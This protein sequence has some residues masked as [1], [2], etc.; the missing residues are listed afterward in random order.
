MYACWRLVLDSVQA[1][2]NKH[3]DIRSRA[4]QSVNIF[5]CVSILCVRVYVHINASVCTC[6]LIHRCLRVQYN[7]VQYS[8][9]STV[10]T[11]RTATH[12]LSCTCTGLCVKDGR[13]QPFTV[14]NRSPY[15]QLA[16]ASQ[17]K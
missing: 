12:A 3:T 10:Q 7:T 9:D 6:I 11:R 4:Q 14:Y 16:P 5:V 13:I 8:T 1:P 2:A 17:S 15:A